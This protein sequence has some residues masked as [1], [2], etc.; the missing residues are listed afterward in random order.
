MKISSKHD[1]FARNDLNSPFGKHKVATLRA[2]ILKTGQF[3]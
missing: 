3:Q 1:L 2:F